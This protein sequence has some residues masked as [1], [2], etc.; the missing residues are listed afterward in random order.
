MQVCW[1]QVHF[2]ESFSALRIPHHK[3]FSRLH[4]TP[5][6]DLEIYTLAIDKVRDRTYSNLLIY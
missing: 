1:C 2:D 4:I 3:G 6:G 5:E